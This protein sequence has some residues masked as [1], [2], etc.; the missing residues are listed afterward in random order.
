MFDVIDQ[1]AHRN[2]CL[3]PM[4]WVCYKCCNEYPGPLVGFSASWLDVA[5]TARTPGDC[6]QTLLLAR[7]Q[8]EFTSVSLWIQ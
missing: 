5:K 1:S 4:L 2:I 3:Q 8:T 6:I 7:K